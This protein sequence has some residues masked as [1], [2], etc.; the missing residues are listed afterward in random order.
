MYA[1]NAVHYRC[2][3]VNMWKPESPR[4]YAHGIMDGEAFML[5]ELLPRMRPWVMMPPARPHTYNGGG[6]NS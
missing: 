4:Y 2:D 6:G 1:Y 5:P 3:V